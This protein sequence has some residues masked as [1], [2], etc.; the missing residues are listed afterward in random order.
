M[1]LPQVVVASVTTRTVPVI[2]NYV[3][4][5]RAT[6]TVELCARVNGY[7]VEAPVPEGKFVKAGDLL[8]LIDPRP[9]EADLIEARGRLDQSLANRLKA[10]LDVERNAPLLAENAIARRDADDAQ[11]NYQAQIASVQTA[12]AAVT[13]AALNLEWCRVVAPIDGMVGARLVDKGN[14]VSAL[15]NSPL[16]TLS[17]IDPMQVWFSISEMDYIRYGS[18]LIKIGGAEAELRLADGSTYPHK[19]TVNF[20]DR[21]LAQST[22]TLPMRAA[23]PNPD[24]TL[25]PGQFGR[26]HIKVDTMENALVIPE[27]AITEL[28]SLKTVLVVGVDAKVEQRA[29]TTSI[30]YEGMVVVATGLKAGERVIVDGL[31]KVRPGMACQ[32]VTEEDAVAARKNPVSSGA[33]S[34]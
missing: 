26:I 19:G 7:I 10:Q 9:Y 25:R 30:R 4:E 31:L 33:K 5:T 15:K 28:Q 17:D 16:A 8:F 2:L 6:T 23:F 22:G 20:A 32:P 13:N 24:S 21:G 3:G 11:A 1:P 12:E 34:R 18:A 27:K 29:V 14:L